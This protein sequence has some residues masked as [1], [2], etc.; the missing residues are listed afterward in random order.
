[1]SSWLFH[2]LKKSKSDVDII[3]IGRKYNPAVYL[4]TLRKKFN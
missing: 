4:I 3:R 2:Y 1:M